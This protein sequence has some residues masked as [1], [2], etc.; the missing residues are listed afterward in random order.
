MELTLE[1]TGPQAAKLAAAARRQ[2]GAAGGTIGRLRENT[3]TLTDPWV[4]ARHARITFAGG[5][6]YIEDTSTN[7]VFVNSPDNRLVSGQPY[8]LKPGDAIFI[9]PVRDSRVDQCCRGD[10]R[11]LRRSLRAR[12]PV[13][14]ARAAA[15]AGSAGSRHAVDA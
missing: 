13:C 5:T 2:F 7:G 12:R 6:F 3:W 9:D 14:R 10:R 8:A 4:S 15:V 1:V 11:S